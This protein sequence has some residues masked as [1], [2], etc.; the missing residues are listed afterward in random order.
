[1]KEPSFTLK[2][3][4]IIIRC[5]EKSLPQAHLLLRNTA[6]NSQHDGNPFSCSH[7]SVCSA[8]QL[9]TQLFRLAQALA[10]KAIR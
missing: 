4:P 5:G 7:V 10:C 9:I 8:E 3:K 1:V 2:S 6:N